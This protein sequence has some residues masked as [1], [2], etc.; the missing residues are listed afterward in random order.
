MLQT[1]TFG[2]L[3]VISEDVVEL[4]IDHGNDFGSAQVLELIESLEL[5][6]HTPFALLINLIKPVSVST[7]S[8]MQL[9][10]HEPL[11]AIAAVHFFTLTEAT[12]HLENQDKFNMRW[13]SGFELGRQH[14]LNWL[15][16]ELS[17]TPY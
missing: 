6:I 14:G 4:V 16:L 7:R 12:P 11:V 3:N 15:A 1:L 5:F 8:L 10:E 17:K 9:A 13:F 2:Q